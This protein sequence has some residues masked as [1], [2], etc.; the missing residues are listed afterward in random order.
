M[1]P[2]EDDLLR[3]LISK[4]LHSSPSLFKDDETVD[5]LMKNYTVSVGLGWILLLDSLF[6][7]IQREKSLLPLEVQKVIYI[8]QVKEKFGELR[9]YLFQELPHMTGA[10]EMASAYSVHICE[11]CGQPGTIRVPLRGW[12]KTLCEVHH[13]ERELQKS[14]Q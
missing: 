14:K 12:I 5:S 1:I 11:K 4:Y 9:V 6:Q 10:I 3:D 2:S 8:T 13:Q 7:T